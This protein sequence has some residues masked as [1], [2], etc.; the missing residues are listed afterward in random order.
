MKTIEIPHHELKE[1]FIQQLRQKTLLTK[2]FNGITIGILIIFCI[3]IG[4]SFLQLFLSNANPEFSLF[5]I[6]LG[7]LCIPFLIIIHELIHGIAYKICGAKNV[8]Y[9]H[10]IKKFLFYAASDNHIVTG[11]QLAFIAL[12]PLF[13]IGVIL[14]GL[15]VIDTTHLNAY[16]SLFCFHIISCG[17][18]IAA[19]NF[20]LLHGID[21]IAT[22]DVKQTSMTYYYIS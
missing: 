22:K 15:M 18:D 5:M 1:F 2:A 14:L 7:L 9:G 10:E 13:V 12:L 8:Y 19:V 20:L 17:G 21:N 16:L 4:Y 11:K 6:G 3:M